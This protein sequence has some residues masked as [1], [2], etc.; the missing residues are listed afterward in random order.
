M[1]P[2]A[3]V[4]AVL[5][6]CAAALAVAAPAQADSVVGTGFPSGLT[7]FVTIDVHSGPSGESPT[8]FLETT[9]TG[10]RV[11]ASCLHVVGNAAVIN[12]TSPGG[13]PAAQVLIV[14]NGP[15]GDVFAA[16]FTNTPAVCP[17]PADFV[18][19]LGPFPLSSGDFVVA[20]EQPLPT[21]K[22]QCKD[23]GW[24]RFPG[25]T[26]PGDCVS[27]VATKGRNPPAGP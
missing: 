21:S 1:R 13:G 16:T 4:R 12:F 19:S 10:G 7:T 5:A 25:F 18:P 27:F 11:P 22:D 26:S 23:G 2:A 6:G 8:G 17:A 24:R 3:S 20:D 15:T 9:F 14:D